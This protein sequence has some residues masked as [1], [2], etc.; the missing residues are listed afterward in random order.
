MLTDLR[1]VER[2]P[3]DFRITNHGS[4]VTFQPLSEAAQEHCEEWFPEDCPMFG[5]AYAVEHR[6]A[7]AILEDLAACGF[8][9][10]K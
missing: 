3:P 2:K 1:L 5:P 9:L 4:I 7:P 8:D 6:F 10:G